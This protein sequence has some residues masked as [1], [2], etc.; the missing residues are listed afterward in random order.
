MLEVQCV[1]GRRYSVPDDKGGKKLQCKR[2]GAVNR[3]PRPPAPDA[4]DDVVIP[5]RDPGLDDDGLGGGDLDLVAP[6]APPP[7]D[8][9]DPLRRCPSCGFQ[10]EAT[11]LLCVRCGYDFRSGRR[12]E[13]AHEREERSGR[14]R[15]VSETAT[16]V[17]RLS[18]LAWA[19][20]TP[21]GL[22]L[23]PYLLVRG[24]GLERQAR[25]LLGR[26]AAALH[27]VRTLGL[28]G[29]VGW[30]L[31]LGA[32]G[33]VA[34]RRGQA[35]QGGVDAECRARLERV[36]AAL[37]ARLEAERRFPPAGSD[38]ERGLE[39]L[40][41][42]GSPDLS[43]PVGGDLYPFRRR[44]TADLVT[45]QA[46]DGYLVAWEREPHVDGGGLLVY[47]A[48]RLDGRVE[49][50]A[51]RAELEEASRRPPF[52]A[53][54]A[55]P[56]EQPPPGPGAGQ[57]T[58]PPPT[59][60]AD[61]LEAARQS[62]MAYAGSVDDM[63]PTF[64]EGVAIDPEFFTERVGVP[65]EELLPLLLGAP[66]PEVR[67]Q[68][69][70]MAARVALPRDLSLQLAR[71]AVKDDD[72]EVRVGGAV[73]LHRH[74]DEGWLP[75]MAALAE[76]ALDEETRGLAS[77]WI[78]REALRGVAE[79][80][81]LLEFGARL[82][83]RTGAKGAD[84]MVRLPA[85]ALPH[86]VALLTDQAVRRE[87]LAT[88]YTAGE[89]ALPAL[90]AELGPE[91]PRDA[92]QAAL[93]ALD[94][95]RVRGALPLEEYLRLVDEELDPDVRSL[96]V[97]ELAG[98]G[99]D[100]PVALLEW[101]LAALRR[102]A[103]GSLHAQCERVIVRA[104]LGPAGEASLERMIADLSREGDRG[105]LLHVL[106]TGPARLSDER[107]DRLL[108]ARWDKVPDAATRVEL[109]RL[110]QERPHEGAQR[111][112]LVAAQDAAEEV[113][114]EAARALR[115]AV[116]V[117]GPELRREAARIVGQRLR[118][119]KSP[120][121][122]EGLLLLAGTSLYCELAEGGGREHRCPVALTR[123]LE[124]LARKGDRAA[125]RA[126]RGHVTD[127]VL[128][129]FISMLDST[130]EEGMR[131]ELLTG[132][133][134]ITNVASGVEAA[135]WRKMLQPMPPHVAQFMAEQAAYEA[136][137]QR[138]AQE[139]AE[140]RIQQLRLAAEGPR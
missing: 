9:R 16:E 56:P 74:G 34:V 3:I 53:V 38:W 140:Q 51:S 54:A 15:A 76:E 72:P 47:R 118:A 45:P 13:D 104:G 69:A 83:H 40:V 70:R 14:Q 97:T 41:G 35:G 17:E 23:G 94:T 37:R 64:T 95:L 130:R 96:A 89:E 26:E 59:R 132:L 124:Q 91:R 11:V 99:G 44:A 114:I 75:V 21:L 129:F 6:P 109:V 19:A 105:R 125:V 85:G 121:A 55:P 81:K 127:K 20:L 27:R 131:Q 24:L 42:K 98:Q 2:C 32:L 112:L 39:A 63:D 79:V 138:G 103:Q 88:I 87:A 119:E 128:E 65:P 93:G 78:A 52:A 66:E 50:F 82:R 8:I 84:A 101:A 111:V 106:R 22:V 30:V 113:R 80:R 58:P 12:L 10:D 5:F 60:P 68:A 136:H 133:Q 67:T 43:C 7:L 18:G 116:A 120:R 107:I 62:F 46:D 1:C 28:V 71:R 135:D 100:P 31:A 117:R 108:A 123:S 57:G 134:M 29:L 61:R 33:V 137:R 110:L 102:G 36:G 86:V 73:A 77:A 90:L 92:R 139:Q 122:M 4:D 25:A 115:E 48:L 126:L 49:T